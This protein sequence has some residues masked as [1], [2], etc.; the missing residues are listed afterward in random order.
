MEGSTAAKGMKAI[1]DQLV[2]G[3]TA[4]T[5]FEVVGEVMPFVIK[6]VP[7]A[8]GLHELRKVIKGASKAK[9]KF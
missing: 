6:M 1:T 4:E 8:L 7:I 2:A 9:V 3:V 5:I